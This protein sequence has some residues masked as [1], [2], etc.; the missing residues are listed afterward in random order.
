MFEIV[1]AVL[2]GGVP[3]SPPSQCCSGPVVVAACLAPIDAVLMCIRGQRIPRRS[4][5]VMAAVRSPKRFPR[6][7]PICI[8][9]QPQYHKYSASVPEHDQCERNARRYKLNKQNECHY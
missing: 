3:A 4:P 2:A 1:V 8:V 6:L 7:G 9:H 5:L